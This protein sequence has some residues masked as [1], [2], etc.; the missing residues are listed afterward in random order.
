MRP[1][2]RSAAQR[3]SRMEARKPPSGLVAELGPAPTAACSWL[4]P[5]VREHRRLLRCVRVRNLAHHFGPMDDWHVLFPE[6]RDS[7]GEQQHPAG[8]F[9]TFG[10]CRSGAL[11]YRSAC[12]FRDEANDLLEAER[13]ARSAS[14]PTRVRVSR[15][16]IPL[17]R[18]EPIGDRP[19][20]FH[21]AAGRTRRIDWRERARQNHHRK[22]HYK[23]IRP[24][25]RTSPAR[26]N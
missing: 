2:R 19:F 13:S 8:I 4:G 21:I 26:W 3:R 25:R 24:Q 23:T 15:C 22:A 16:F 7:A 6:H 14:N 5:V 1:P 12:V 20:E 18:Y 9:N 11:P 17:S 10:N